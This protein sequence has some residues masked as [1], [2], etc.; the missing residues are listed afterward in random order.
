MTKILIV[1]MMIFMALSMGGSRNA[2]AQTIDFSQYLWKNRL[3]LMFAPDRSHPAFDALHRSLLAQGAEVSDRDLVI[4]EIIESG[5]S[6]INKADLTSEAAHLLREKFNADMGK[7][8]VIL[9]GKDGGVKLNRGDQTDLRDIFALI[10]SMPM[11]REEMRQ[12]SQ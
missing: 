5:P 12:K 7:F 6:R 3:L 9:I 1:V 10:D 4:F 11:R 2:A 8:R